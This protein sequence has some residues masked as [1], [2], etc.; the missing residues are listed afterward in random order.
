MKPKP[1][2]DDQIDKIFT[3]Y[4][5]RAY[6]HGIIVGAALAGMVWAIGRLVL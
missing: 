3:S 2:Y 1:P 4:M 5:N 6:R